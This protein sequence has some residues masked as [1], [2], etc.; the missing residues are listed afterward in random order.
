[1]G[2]PAAIYTVEGTEKWIIEVVEK[3]KITQKNEKSP[4]QD[5]ENNSG[6][7]RTIGTTYTCISTIIPLGSIPNL[8][9]ENK[10]SVSST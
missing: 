1:M 2:S 10:I 4:E 9:V 5:S 6:I 8:P 3:R 7:S